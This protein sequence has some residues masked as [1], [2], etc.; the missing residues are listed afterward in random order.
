MNLWFLLRLLGSMIAT[1]IVLIVGYGSLWLL[2]EVSHS[3]V[4]HWM[5]NIL[6]IILGLIG[7]VVCMILIGVVVR[8]VRG[9]R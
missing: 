9:R 7:L 3:S 1:G 8:F 2:W 4:G 6:G 5:L